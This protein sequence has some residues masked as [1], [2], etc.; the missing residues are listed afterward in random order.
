MDP[1]ST[2]PAVDVGFTGVRAASQP[3]AN[4]AGLGQQIPLRRVHLVWPEKVGLV[5]ALAVAVLSALF[6]V[7]VLYAADTVS[8]GKLNHALAVWSGV[9]ELTVALPIW[10]LMRGVDFAANGPARRRANRKSRAV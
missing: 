7:T 2:N 5:T 9:A 6:C 1:C 10:L 4:R 8:F 3:Y